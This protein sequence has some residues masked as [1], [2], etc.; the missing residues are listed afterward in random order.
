MMFLLGGVL[1]L[2]DLFWVQI[3]SLLKVLRF[4]I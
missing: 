4:Q 1:Y 2:Y 3:L